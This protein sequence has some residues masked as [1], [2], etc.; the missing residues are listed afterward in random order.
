[1]SPA[2]LNR[3]QGDAGVSLVE[4]LV[5]IVLVGVVFGIALTM[6]TS[7]QRSAD[8]TTREHQAIEEAR[9]GL[10]RVSRELRQA[11]DI[12]YALNAD[13]PGRSESGVTM[14]SFD[15]DFNGDGCIAG[16]A[17]CAA[18]NPADPESLTYCHQPPAD[19][20]E[21]RLYIIPQVVTAPTSSCESLGVPILAGR[22]DRF[23]VEYRSNLYRYDLSPT[24]GITTWRELDAAPVPIGNSNGLLD[25][26][27]ASIKAVVVDLTLDAGSGRTYRTH[28]ALRNKP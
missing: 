12:R 26:E 3:P 11:T 14:V 16:S 8:G 21:G 10:N 4:M 9:L 13:G 2:R 24:D 6:V 1:M 5:G 22:V 25:A 28:I 20:V 15:A 18:V 7:A 27:L 19:G 17:G 23:L